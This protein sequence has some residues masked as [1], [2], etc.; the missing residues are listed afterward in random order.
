MLAVV[1]ALTL[2]VA[3]EAE[4]QSTVNWSRGSEEVIAQAAF[5]ALVPQ[6]K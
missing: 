4:L 2:A 3:F 6:D 1:V 5:G